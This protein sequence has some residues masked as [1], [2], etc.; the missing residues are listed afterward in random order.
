MKNVARLLLFMLLL[1]V[2][3]KV[4]NK[5]NDQSKDKETIALVKQ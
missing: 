4:L 1:A 5:T 3:V 2:M